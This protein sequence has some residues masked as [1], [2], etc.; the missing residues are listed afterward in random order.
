MLQKWRFK[1]HGF[2]YH[3]YHLL[4]KIKNMSVVNNGPMYLISAEI[5]S[6]SYASSSRRVLGI[7]PCLYPLGIGFGGFPYRLPSGFDT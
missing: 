2:F 4:K 6:P 1:T 3:V 5:K 7:P